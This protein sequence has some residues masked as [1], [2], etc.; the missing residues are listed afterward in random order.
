MRWIPVAV[1]AAAFQVARNAAQRG[2]MGGAGPWGATLTRF[3]FGLPFTLAFTVVVWVFVHPV[4]VHPTPLYLGYA[5]T[6]ALGQVL[7]TA[8]LLTSLHRAG[9]GVGTAVQQ[10]SLPLSGVV[11]WLVFG[12]ALSPTAW[13]GVAIATVG[14]VA[15]SWSKARDIDRGAAGGRP[16]SGA[17]FALLSGLLFGFS[18][19]AYRHAGLVLEPDHP[20]FS[21]VATVSFTQAAQSVVL[22]VVLAIRHPAA[23][24][25]VLTDWRRSLTSGFC[26][27]CASSAWVFALALAPA[28]A[29]RAV[30]VVEAPMAAAVGRRLFAERLSLGKLAAGALTAVGVLLTAL[31]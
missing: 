10:S 17:V 31:G 30:G 13:A 25:A 22:G 11:G 24:E 29:V 6:G 2:L 19:N 12:D 16:V 23:L 27:A 7:A 14:L 8:A 26:G 9:F 21:A 1:A 5:L 18:L 4:T 20:L 3:L 28:A 15:L